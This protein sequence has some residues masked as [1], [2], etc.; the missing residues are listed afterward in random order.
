[1]QS[2]SMLLKF[3]STCGGGADPR[4]GSGPWVGPVRPSGLPLHCRSPASAHGA[5]KTAGQ[6]LAPAACP[7]PTLGSRPPVGL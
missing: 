6:P 5:E 3:C 1:M 7:A 2:S 4:T